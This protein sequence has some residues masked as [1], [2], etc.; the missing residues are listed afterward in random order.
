MNGRPCKECGARLQWVP[1]LNAKTDKA[2][3]ID[4]APTDKGNIRITV[5]GGKEMAVV[6][7]GSKLEDARAAGEKLFLSHFVTCT[8]PARFKR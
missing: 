5:I 3:P 6:L 4:A 7:S 1:M 8:N 2:K